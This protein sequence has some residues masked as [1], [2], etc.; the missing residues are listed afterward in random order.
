M[1]PDSVRLN[2]TTEAKNM[3]NCLEHG[4]PRA[5]IHLARLIETDEKGVFQ[6]FADAVAARLTD[7]LS[8][9]AEL[10]ETNPVVTLEDEVY[11]ILKVASIDWDGLHAQGRPG[12]EV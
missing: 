11:Q 4:D 9:W 5:S 12:E 6:P 3:A 10:D 8:R 2:P 7:H 1:I